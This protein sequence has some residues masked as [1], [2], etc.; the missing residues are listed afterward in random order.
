MTKELRKAGAQVDLWCL[1]REG[2]IDP[3]I[4]EYEDMALY[5]KRILE[6]MWEIYQKLYW[7]THLKKAEKA[8]AVDD[9]KVR[10]Y[11]YSNAIAATSGLLE[12]AR[13]DTE[14]PKRAAA[15]E[16]ARSTRIEEE[17]AGRLDTGT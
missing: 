7:S 5:H 14:T 10:K 11:H 3:Q 9:Y 1:S 17:E 6:D 16:V 15:E 2:L 12:E 4:C 8:A 13:A